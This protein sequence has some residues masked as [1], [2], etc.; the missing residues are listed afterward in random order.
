MLN[1]ISKKSWHDALLAGTDLIEIDICFLLQKNVHIAVSARWGYASCSRLE[2]LH[3]W[4]GGLINWI[5]IVLHESLKYRKFGIFIQVTHTRAAVHP[6][7]A[8]QHGT[9]G[10]LSTV[11]PCLRCHTLQDP[12]LRN[13]VWRY[14][15]RNPNVAAAFESTTHGVPVKTLFLKGTG[16]GLALACV[17]AGWSHL[18]ACQSHSAFLNYY[19]FV[20]AFS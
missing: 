5:R 14:D 16:T 12:W 20:T 11:P 2:A 17:S 3:C 9:Q 7:N 4:V 13:E 1:S 10:T 6:K 18:L 15:R 8:E 19:T